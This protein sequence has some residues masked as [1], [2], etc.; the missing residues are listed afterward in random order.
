MRYLGQAFIEQPGQAVCLVSIEG[1]ASGVGTSRQPGR[2]GRGQ[3]VL[4]PALL[5][6]FKSHSV[7]SPVAM[8]SVSWVTSWD[9]V[10]T[11]QIWCAMTGQFCVA[12][13]AVDTGI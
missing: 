12:D 4:C 6:V 13:N 5:S 3:T 2:I 9:T 10:S 7:G 11:G 8:L 1:A